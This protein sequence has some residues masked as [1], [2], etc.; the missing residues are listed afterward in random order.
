MQLSDVS[1]HYLVVSTDPAPAAA[2]V[3]VGTSGQA[4]SATPAGKKGGVITVTVT[5]TDT[6]ERKQVFG[7]EAR[8]V[9]IV[10]ER[11]PDANACDKHAERVSVDGWYVDAPQM[12]AAC[13][14]AATGKPAATP[15]SESSCTDRVETKTVGTAVMGLAVASTI[16]TM[17]GPADTL[18]AADGGRKSEKDK[19][20][21]KGD[22]TET[23]VTNVEVVALETKTVEASFFD[24]PADY[25]EVRT[26]A[27][28]LST[29]SAL[30]AAA[31]SDALSDALMGS[32]ADGTRTVVPKTA[33]VTRVGLAPLANTSGREM[34]TSALN[35]NLMASLNKAPYDSVPLVGSTP[36][37]LE[38]DARAKGCD[39]ILTSTLTELRSSKPGKAGGLLKKVSGDFTPG[40]DNHDARVEY[41]LF[42]V[43]ASDK[44]VATGTSK[45]SSGGGFGVGSALKVAAFAG[46]LYLGAMTGM[47]GMGQFSALTG[48]GYGG[49]MGGL[50]LTNAM[51]G[52]GMSLAMASMSQVP[53]GMPEVDQNSAA[54]ERTAG[55]AFRKAGGDVMEALR[56]KGSQGR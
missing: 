16:T 36:A 19:E 51:M 50:G 45:A 28:L 52:P 56:K 9:T 55:D 13:S 48:L 21:D 25:T 24:I 44:P 42:A 20:K 32:V 23:S 17:R 26:M 31:V 7:R 27:E 18:T 14:T 39:Y 33:G 49:G 47:G 15:A 12:A 11:Q 22:A 43:D 54:A 41:K 3:P 46:Q 30:P 6:G 10:T 4:D 8:H 1:K 53:G 35:Y 34:P 38:R 5:T 37:D 40:S 2:P 29:G